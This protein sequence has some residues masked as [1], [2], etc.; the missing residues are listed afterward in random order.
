MELS[1]GALSDGR[2]DLGSVE[3]TLGISGEAVRCGWNSLNS[4][5]SK[6]EPPERGGH[7]SLPKQSIPSQ[8]S[9]MSPGLVPLSTGSSIARSKRCNLRWVL[10]AFCPLVW[11]GNLDV[12]QPSSKQMLQLTALPE[13]A[14][15]CPFHRNVGVSPYLRPPAGVPPWGLLSQLCPGNSI[16]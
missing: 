14:S 12:L 10:P 5:G 2:G 4:D 16:P 8:A 11:T 15:K 6:E 1:A 9:G 13:L 3:A 7:H